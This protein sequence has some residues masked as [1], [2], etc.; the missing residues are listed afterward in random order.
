[1]HRKLGAVLVGSCF[2]VFGSGY[3]AK[4]CLYKLENGKKC[5]QKKAE[6]TKTDSLAFFEHR[7]LSFRQSLS[8]SWNDDIQTPDQLL[9]FL[10]RVL[11]H[12]G[13]NPNTP[14]I[15]TETTFSELRDKTKDELEVM[16]VH[17]Q[18]R[19]LM[20]YPDGKGIKCFYSG[21]EV[22]PLTHAGFTML[23]FDQGNPTLK[24]DEPGQTWLLSAWGMNRYKHDMSVSPGSDP[25][26]CK[27]RYY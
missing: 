7:T 18:K 20:E 21:I 5:N 22:V 19:F 2:S 6:A 12:Y 4:C 24:S 14:F 16:L 13:T 1:M 8:H 3:H 25:T 23:S 27:S 11:L 26:L 10:F 9:V 15:V 17:L